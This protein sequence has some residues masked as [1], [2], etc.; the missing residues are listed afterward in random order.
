MRVEMRRMAARRIVVGGWCG[1]F[2]G[3]VVSLRL[4]GG[5]VRPSVTVRLVGVICRWREELNT[6]K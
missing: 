3:G 1:R 6:Y 2:G 5:F 4:G